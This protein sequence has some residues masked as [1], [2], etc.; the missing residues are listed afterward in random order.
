MRDERFMLI[1]V[2][3]IGTLM[4]AGALVLLFNA[5]GCSTVNPC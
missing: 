1:A 5:A 3:I 4:W 2:C